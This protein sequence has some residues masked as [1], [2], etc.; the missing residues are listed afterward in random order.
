MEIISIL[1]LAILEESSIFAVCSIRN[2]FLNG[3]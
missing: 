1:H 2:Y 3:G